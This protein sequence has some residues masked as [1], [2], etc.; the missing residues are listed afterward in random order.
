MEGQTDSIL[1]PNVVTNGTSDPNV[2]TSRTPS[3][4][5]ST[6]ADQD[7]FVQSESP[8]FKTDKHFPTVLDSSYMY[9]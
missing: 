4:N 7:S 9:F 2:H 5:V 8:H 6:Y 3:P 1:N